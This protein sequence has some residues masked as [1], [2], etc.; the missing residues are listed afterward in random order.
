MNKLPTELVEKL[1]STSGNFK[2]T[3][4][5][6]E[7]LGEE[8]ITFRELDEIAI[9][10][11]YVE[12]DEYIENYG[13]QSTELAGNY[14]PISGYDLLLDFPGYRA[15]GVLVWLPGTLEFATY[16]E[17]HCV[18][19]SFPNCGFND[20]LKNPKRFFNCMWYPDEF[21][22]HLVRPWDDERFGEIVPT[23]T[24]EW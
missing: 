24:P 3:T 21:E 22:N 15:F 6:H 4:V 10:T 14:Y 5:L 7:E 23:K 20:I 2:L 16:D 9:A 13:D 11:L 19:R 1:K 17:D 12:V 18:L 8:T